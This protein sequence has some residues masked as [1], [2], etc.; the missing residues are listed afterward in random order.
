MLLIT[1]RN[2]DCSICERNYYC[3]CKFMVNH[4]LLI[5]LNTEFEFVLLTRTLSSQIM[6]GGGQLYNYIQ[7]AFDLHH[8]F[9]WTPAASNFNC[10]PAAFP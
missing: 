10:F 7:H 4:F 5:L 6:Y 8:N 1:D 9:E 2:I 3:Y